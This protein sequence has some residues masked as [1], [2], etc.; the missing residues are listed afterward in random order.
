MLSL[1]AK[2]S[3]APE[4]LLVVTTVDVVDVMLLAFVVVLLVFVG[5]FCGDCLTVPLLP[6]PPSVE[7]APS[8]RLGYVNAVRLWTAAANSGKLAALDR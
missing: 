2:L 1:A 5:L 4:R 7:L 3:F 8:L 6:F